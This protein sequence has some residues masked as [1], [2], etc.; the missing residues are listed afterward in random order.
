[1]TQQ[2]CDKANMWLS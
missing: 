1:M 2:T